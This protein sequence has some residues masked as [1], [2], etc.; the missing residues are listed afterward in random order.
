MRIE[1]IERSGT[2]YYTDI[3][4]AEQALTIQPKVVDTKVADAIRLKETGF[5]ADEVFRLL[6]DDK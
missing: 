5:T 2:Y 1:V 3:Y 6:R 4:N